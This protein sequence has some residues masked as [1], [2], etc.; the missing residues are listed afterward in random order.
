M[1][2]GRRNIQARDRVLVQRPIIMRR[3][4]LF[5]GADNQIELT[6]TK[7]PAIPLDYAAIT[8][9][10]ET[11]GFEKWSIRNEKWGLSDKDIEDNLISAT[12]LNGGTSYK[13]PVSHIIFKGTRREVTA[14][15]DLLVGGGYREAIIESAFHEPV[16]G[17][18]WGQ[19]RHGN[20][21]WNGWACPAFPLESIQQLAKE[22]DENFMEKG[23]GDWW[24]LNE[25]DWSMRIH[26]EQ[27][28][29]EPPDEYSP[30]SEWKTIDVTTEN[31]T[32]KVK[33]IWPGAGY[34][35]EEQ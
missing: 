14:K 12:P 3:P 9:H 32:E 25:E 30:H 13:V 7:Y 1:K 29:E 31:G 34:M 27:D 5:I 35:W 2:F 21:T 28:S 16:K 20:N 18:L 22:F 19:D 26:M 6:M 11:G 15:Y 4:V 23:Y 10:P 24:E 8:Q 33:V 17:Y